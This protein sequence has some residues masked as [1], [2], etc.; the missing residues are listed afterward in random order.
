MID[1]HIDLDNAEK[2][3]ICIKVSFIPFNL[4]SGSDSSLDFL[5]RI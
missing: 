5:D 1:E 2:Q 3:E 4:E